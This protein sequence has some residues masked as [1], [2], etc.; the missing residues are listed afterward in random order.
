LRHCAIP[1]EGH[2][3]VKPT[4]IDTHTAGCKDEPTPQKLAAA[5]DDRPSVKSPSTLYR[6]L[7]KKLYR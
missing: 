5:D 1:L 3:E 2:V 6:F 4:Q 7:P